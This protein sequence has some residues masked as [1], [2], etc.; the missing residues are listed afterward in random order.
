LLLLSIDDKF[1]ILL[2]ALSLSDSAAPPPNLF[3]PRDD[4]LLL[5]GFETSPPFFAAPFLSSSLLDWSSPSSSLNNFEL[6]DSRLRPPPPPTAA[7]VALE[8]AIPLF[9][10]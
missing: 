1:F 3:N 8:P 2:E 9:L 7:D 10:G 4:W 6:I 5:L